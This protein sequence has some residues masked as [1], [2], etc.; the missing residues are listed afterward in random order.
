MYVRPALTRVKNA[1]MLGRSRFI[2]SISHGYP[3]AW[4]H[5]VI[6]IP[7]LL[8]TSSKA[9]KHQII[10]S[11]GSSHRFTLIESLFSRPPH[12]QQQFTVWPWIFRCM[13]CNIH[14]HSREDSID[15]QRHTPRCWSNCDRW[16]RTY[17]RFHRW[18]GNLQRRAHVS[19]T[20]YWLETLAGIMKSRSKLV[21]NK[22]R[23]SSSSSSTN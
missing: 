20:T 14:S 16:S 18:K 8:S 3:Q 23:S 2:I 1:I 10:L 19:S 9:P 12:E 11:G 13:G 4:L 5:E 17:R 22:K 21:T 6:P 7:Y 15:V